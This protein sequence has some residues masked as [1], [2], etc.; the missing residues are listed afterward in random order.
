LNYL[1]K[2]KELWKKQRNADSVRERE[3][4][5]EYLVYLN[6]YKKFGF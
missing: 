6:D 2:L 5:D 3:K 4:I 1:L